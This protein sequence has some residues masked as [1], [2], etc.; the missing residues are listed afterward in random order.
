[1]ETIKILCKTSSGLGRP[2]AGTHGGPF[3]YK[4]RNLISAGLGWPQISKQG[5]QPNPGV[6]HAPQSLRQTRPRSAPG[7]RLGPASERKASPT[8]IA[9]TPPFS[10]C[11]RP[12]VLCHSHLHKWQTHLCPSRG[13]RFWERLRSLQA[14]PAHARTS[15]LQLGSDVV[16]CS[17]ASIFSLKVFQISGDPVTLYGATEKLVAVWLEEPGFG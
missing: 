10:C 8:G 11:P 9:L 14:A 16:N 15:L 6:G 4:S 5:G 17:Q 13:G 12:T 7:W 2:R 3:H 1:M